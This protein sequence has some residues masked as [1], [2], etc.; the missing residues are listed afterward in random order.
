MLSLQL[1]VH[2]PSSNSSSSSGPSSS[3]SS[4]QTYR[5]GVPL[6]SSLSNEILLNP[7][8]VRGEDPELHEGDV[9]EICRASNAS[10]YC[11]DVGETS[12]NGSGRSD[13]LLFV[14]SKASIAPEGSSAQLQ[15]GLSY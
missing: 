10:S 5:Y 8:L 2:E 1:W 14:V 4:S 9:V 7:D 6:A 11:G 15:V 3:S 12:G 13:T